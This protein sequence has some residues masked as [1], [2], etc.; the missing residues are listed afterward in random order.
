MKPPKLY[1]KV[2]L[3]VWFSQE[4]HEGYEYIEVRRSLRKDKSCFWQILHPYYKNEY[5]AQVDGE[6]MD[7]WLEHVF[8]KDHNDFDH[9]NCGTYNRATI[10]KQL[11][12][13]ST[14]VGEIDFDADIPY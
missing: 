8:L 11:P 6:E 10:I 5:G 1:R 7:W 13:I 14:V 4:D 2:W 9:R 3:S 12:A